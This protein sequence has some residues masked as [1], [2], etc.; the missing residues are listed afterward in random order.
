MS[1]SIA[2]LS[3]S[4]TKSFI[5]TTFL[6]LILFSLSTFAEVKFLEDEQLSEHSGQAGLTIDL[7]NLNNTVEFEYVDVGTLT[8]P[9]Y[10]V[11]G[12][13]DSHTNPY[14]TQNLDNLRVNISLTADPNDPNNEGLAYGFSE[15]RNLAELYLS[16]GNKSSTE[17]FE[18]LA[19]GYDPLRGNLSVENR[20]KYKEGDLVIH[21][22]YFDAFEKDGGQDAYSE[23]KGLSGNSF[24]DS[25]IDEANQLISSAIDFK[26][27]I[28]EVDMSYGS[29]LLG[30]STAHRNANPRSQ[31]SDPD[32]LSNTTR[33][34][35]NFSVEGYLGPH[36]LHL[37]EI[38]RNNTEAL[39][40]EDRLGITWNSYFKVTDLDVY[41]DIA[42]IQISDVQI[43][44]DRGD[45]SGINL[46][47]QDNS[48]GHSSFGF[49]HAQREIHALQ[50]E[51]WLPKKYGDKKKKKRKGISFNT[52]FQR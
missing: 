34:M 15:F 49:A 37:E 13:G 28:N 52:R 35:S 25:T 2:R 7:S 31:E 19:Q 3:F 39:N 8:G 22:N 1:A 12:H 36:D 23:G 33:L 29:N 40:D 47:T 17:E 5:F 24:I 44:N 14:Y 27:S 42:G 43:H 18:K 9:S 10:L 11:G 26:Y 45:L 51:Y 20:K 38:T 48:V 16:E 41:L 21:L 30:F 32:N 6:F 4:V 46:E 50:D